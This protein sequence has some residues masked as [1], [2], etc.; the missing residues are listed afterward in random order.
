MISLEKVSLI[1]EKYYKPGVDKPV[2]REPHAALGPVSCSSYA[3]TRS[4]TK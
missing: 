1:F 4:P 2:A 3:I